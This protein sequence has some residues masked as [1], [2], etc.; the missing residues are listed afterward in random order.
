M[1]ASS[2]M[3]LLSSPFMYNPF[4]HSSV[5]RHFMTYASFYPCVY[6]RLVLAQMFAQFISVSRYRLIEYER[7]LAEK[8]R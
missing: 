6:V 4:T 7:R 5:F 2:I 3:C 8:I 1:P